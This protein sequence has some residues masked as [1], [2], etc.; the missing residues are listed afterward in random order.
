MDVRDRFFLEI[1]G[2]EDEKIIK[3]EMLSR[4]AEGEA[5]ID[6]THL[7]RWKGEERVYFL[8]LFEIPDIYD[9]RGWIR[10]L[11]LSYRANFLI[12]LKTGKVIKTGDVDILPFEK[13]FIISPQPLSF[14]FEK[15]ETILLW[16]VKE[17]SRGMWKIMKGY[18]REM[19]HEGPQP[20]LPLR[21]LEFY[22]TKNEIT[23]PLCDCGEE[24]VFFER[25]GKKWKMKRIKGEKIIETGLQF[26]FKPEKLWRFDI[27][28]DGVE[29]LVVSSSLYRNKRGIVEIYTGKSL[30]YRLEGEA[31]GAEFGNEVQFCSPYLFI[32][33]PGEDKS[34]G[35]VYVLTNGRP[36]KVLK[37]VRQN[38]RFG[39]SILCY[40]CSPLGCYMIGA[41]GE[42]RGD[43]ALYFFNGNLE[44]SA[45][46]ESHDKA[47][48]GTSS[49]RFRHP[50][51]PTG[52]FI[53]FSAPGFP[54][55]R[56]KLKITDGKSPPKTLLDGPEGWSIGKSLK[57]CDLNRDSFPEII[58]EGEKGYVILF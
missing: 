49:L 10:D 3:W 44:I 2:L 38:S 17:N 19:L 43:G 55:G 37:P 39:E 22:S 33:A 57:A 25:G 58:I 48:L 52:E 27:N 29:E 4:D 26:P 9:F 35:K 40:P 8:Y 54:Q 41:P 16:S 28:E 7:M 34:G 30:L 1:R 14:C 11:T 24:A 47:Q 5:V 56:G 32:S 46:F 12:T 13:K 53:I 45:H 20:F 18:L 51:S 23:P 15:E 50:S 21:K 31:D 42:N 36:V 6:V